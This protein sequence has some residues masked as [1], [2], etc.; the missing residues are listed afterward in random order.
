MTQNHA[1]DSAQTSGERHARDAIS[2][3]R[4]IR[5]DGSEWWVYEEHSACDRRQRPDLVFESETTVRR[6]RRYPADWMVMVDG[7]L[8][9]IATDTEG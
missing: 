2:A 5:C 1:L 7:K 3:S 4:V 9:D 6:V 8:L